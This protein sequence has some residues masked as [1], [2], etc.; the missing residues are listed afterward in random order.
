MP[1]NFRPVWGISSELP[2][3]IV[4]GRLYI[5]TDTREILLDTESGDRIS[6]NSLTEL[7]GVLPIESGG[8]GGADRNSARNKL[9]VPAQIGVDPSLS[10][11]IGYGL[12]SSRGSLG[13]TAGSVP[14]TDNYYY[15]VDMQAVLWGGSS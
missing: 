8:T 10:F 7:P 12:L 13:N 4:P 3:D 15:G 5:C 14:A 1:S 11:P 6:L 2:S 9:G